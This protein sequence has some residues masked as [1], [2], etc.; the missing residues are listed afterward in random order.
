MFIHLIMHGQAVN[1]RYVC[2]VEP[3]T[4]ENVGAVKG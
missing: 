3:F 2:C 1:M 4:M